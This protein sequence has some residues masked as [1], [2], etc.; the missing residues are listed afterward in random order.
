MFLQS[1]DAVAGTD[2]KVHADILCYNCQK[3]GHY[4][5]QCP[6]DDGGNNGRGRGRNENVEAV[7]LFQSSHVETIEDASGED[8]ENGDTIHC[9]LFNQTH[10]NIPESWIL[11]DSQSTACV[12]R[13]GDFLSNIRHSNKR[14]ILKT[15]GGEH[16]SNM[17]GDLENFGEVWFN[18]SSLANIL[19]LA[20]VRKKC[21]VTMDTS[22]E[23]AFFVHRNDGTTLKFKEFTSGLYFYNALDNSNVSNASDSAYCM[24]QTV[25]SNKL[26]FHRREVE[27]A[28]KA[29]ELYRKLGRPSQ[30]RFEH[31]LSHNS[32]QNCPVT[33]AD[34]KRAV[35]IYGP[36]LGFLKGKMT[37]RKGAHVPSFT[38]TALPSYIM[39]HHQQ[40]TLYEDFFFVQGIPFLHT[41]S[42]KLNFRTATH[43]TDRQ[44]ATMVSE[45]TKIRDLYEDRGFNV[46]DIHADLEFECITDE[47]RPTRMVMYAADDHVGPIERSIRTVKETMR[48]TTGGLP[49]KR[50]TRIM[51][52][53]LV[54]HC[55]RCLNQM[56]SEDG[57]SEYMSPL[58]MVTGDGPVD[59]NN[60]KLEFGTY[61][62]VFEDRTI[63]NT[64]AARS[65]GAIALTISPSPSGFYRFMS[66]DTGMLLKRKQYTALPITQAVVERVHELAINQGMPIFKN[67][68]PSITM[69]PDG[70]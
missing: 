65:T 24:V 3:P 56:P 28:D 64:P 26:M 40:I 16:T 62:Q 12:F 7:G 10:H 58:T 33:L 44:K 60:I 59:Y 41:I 52:V 1:T 15:N 30:R 67:G 48:G 39:E 61:C 27:G 32:I 20:M 8:E 45:T 38:P 36:D 17:V 37:R 68:C 57:I 63:T 54:S 29:R 5:G 14:L 50:F 22:N 35:K 66:L 53:E 70:E 25:S 2:G 9:V 34:A 13:N 55:V 42:N 23:A 31:F 21:R 6:A 51:T 18:P 19:S 49:F 43:V 47:M 11:L 69:E 46:V 4:A